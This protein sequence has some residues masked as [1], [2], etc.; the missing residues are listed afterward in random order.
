MQ[1]PAYLYLAAIGV[2]LAMIDFDVR[3]L[4][5]SIVLP[6]YVVSVLLLMPAGAVTGDWWVAARALLGMAALWIIYFVLAL[7]YPNG[8]GFGDVKLAGLLGLYLGWLG[9][10]ALLIG[11]FGAFVIGGLGGTR[12]DRDRS[13]DPLHGDSVR[14]QHGR[15]RRPRRLRRRA[16]R[17]RLRR[18][19]APV[20]TH[21]I[22]RPKEPT[23]S[24]VTHIGLDVGSTSIRAVEATRHQ[25]PP[26][27]QQLRSGDA[28][29]GRNGR[30]ASS[31]TTGRSPR[32]CASSGAAQHFKTKN[33]ILGVSH[34][35]VVVRDVEVSNLPPKEMRQALPFQVRD[36]LPMP[37]EDA[38]LDFYPLEDPGTNDT[39]VGLLIAAPKRAVVDLVN[40]VER[41]GAARHSGR[42]VLL[43]GATRRCPDRRRH[44]GGHRHRCRNH[45][46]D[47]P[48][49]RRAADRPLDPTRWRRDDPRYRDCGWACRMAEAE[50]LKR[51]RRARSA[52]RA[53]RSTR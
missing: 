3:R 21:H 19:G 23:V 22:R 50:A 10:G 25:G 18:N 26:G 5:D 12:D 34:Q 35:Q 7:A 9:W 2:T 48:H 11:G 47:H 24:A 44:R 17:P 41:A 49:R 51:Q 33:V 38:V 46:P 39:V 1:L 28:A 15:G 30:P 43:R 6:S 40:A 53:R 8:M 32:R 4:P 16:D 31:R 20:M 13:G 42:P 29:T 36:V 45:E 14:A 37:V 27:D 52:S